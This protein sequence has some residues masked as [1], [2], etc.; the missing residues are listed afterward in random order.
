MPT[1]GLVASP[2]LEVWIE[3]LGVVP[4]HQGHVRDVVRAHGGDLPQV[5]KILL[6]AALDGLSLHRH[7]LALVVEVV[8][9]MLPF[10]GDVRVP[11]PVAV[12]I[13]LE[14]PQAA[15]GPLVELPGRR[16]HLGLVL[17]KVLRHLARE[18]EAGHG[19]GPPRREEA[20]RHEFRP[21]DH[22]H[23][24][25][26]VDLVELRVLSMVGQQLQCATSWAQEDDDHDLAPQKMSH[27]LHDALL[28]ERNRLLFLVWLARLMHNC[29]GAM[30]HLDSEVAQVGL[31]LESH[32]RHGIVKLRDHLA[33]SSDLVIE[34]RRLELDDLAR[35]LRAQEA[36]LD[37]CVDLSPLPP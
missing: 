8:H 9:G 14:L 22:H 7:H 13:H 27:P 36:V 20:V 31:D 37:D 29:Q 19:E 26:S 15:H 32:V 1:V 23:A 11:R 10:P 28:L 16:D 5:V 2:G 4:S 34:V 35:A 6:H 21:E 25:L 24:R 30:G 3:D 17:R 12:A 33:L 18:E